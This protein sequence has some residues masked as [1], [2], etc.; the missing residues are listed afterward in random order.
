MN[1]ISDFII[2]DGILKKYIGKERN[3]IIPEE[4][5]GIGDAAFCDNKTI[6]SIYMHNGIKTVGKRAFW[7]CR[8]LVDLQFSND[9]IFIDEE[10]LGFCVKLERLIFPENVVIPNI[11][12]VVQNCWNLNEIYLSANI[13]IEADK[14]Y[15][16]LMGAWFLKLEGC[17]KVQRIVAPYI[18][19]NRISEKREFAAV[20]GYLTNVDLF[21]DEQITESYQEC[22]LKKK[23]RFLD[24]IF[25]NDIAQGI[26][27]L[28]ENKK[29]TKANIEKEFLDPAIAMGATQCIA[30]LLEWKNVNDKKALTSMKLKESTKGEKKLKESTKS[31]KD[32][33]NERT[34]RKLWRYE[35]M[36]DN[37][38]RLREYKGEEKEVIVPN[39][40][41]QYI[42][43]SIGPGVFSGVH[44]RGS[45]KLERAIS[46]IVTVSVMDGIVQI[47]SRAFCWC[48]NLKTLKLP[49][50]I[51]KIAQ[52]QF[53]DTENKLVE[54]WA[55]YD[56]PKLT[57]SVAQGSYAKRYAEENNIPFTVE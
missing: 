42:V 8:S 19:L 38:I 49:N 30:V 26:K 15:E 17:N 20:M 34:M 53:N 16:E 13:G 37:T 25:I 36:E 43:S 6:V 51:K 21:C 4:I 57:L 33:Y 7:N 48:T 29:I 18:S 45:N 28:A 46:D 44:G 39:R 52:F 54:D 22:F 1:N 41:G 3:I 50:S 56:C 35:I 9:L 14:E 23:K 31:E 55:F 32:P 12:K 2:E 27:I 24:E 47:E 11:D 5:V 40:I 10:A